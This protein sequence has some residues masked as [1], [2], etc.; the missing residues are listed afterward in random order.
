MT[1]VDHL[2]FLCHRLPFPPQKGEKIRAW[3]MLLHL[4]K[5][6]RVH[7]GCF[8]D[9]PGD[10]Q[11]LGAV[12]RVCA[13]LCAIPLDPLR[14]RLKSLVALATGEPLSTRYFHDIRLTRWVETV[15]ETHRPRHVLAYC[16]SMAPYG[17]VPGI[18][19]RVLDLV[20]VDSEKWRDYATATAWP[21][22]LV[23]RREGATL[24][25]LERRMAAAFDTTLL[26]S[27]D[28]AATFARRAP[29]VAD[30]LR[31]LGNGVDDTYFQPD[32]DRPSPYEAGRPVAVFTGTMDYRPNVDAVV[33]FVEEILP[34][35][36]SRIP[37]VEFWIVGANPAPS[38]M[39]LQRRSNVHV[40]GRVSDV[41]PYLAHAGAV[42][43]PLRIARGIQNKVLEGMAMARPVVATPAALEGLDVVV[44]EDV[45]AATT[46]E[47]F[48]A[49][50][51]AAFGPKGP[52]IGLRARRK[53]VADY[54]WGARLALLDTLFPP[55]DDAGGPIA[56]PSLV[57]GRQ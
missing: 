19:H 37:T 11:H 4:A 2:L 35:I 38:V 52:E 29:E 49:T 42:V 47:A 36:Q 46:A 22:S 31:V 54:R 33:W 23:Y 20:D 48:A 10:A 8:Y 12:H 41:R 32:V 57:R 21:M 51:I 1:A 56:T 14:T 43:A 6:H 40:T 26:V 5:R 16:S 28:E 53:V 44:G 17:L 24:L 50:V 45:L 3:Q 30:S 27:R 34:L 25:T 15:V 18:A 9:D 13:S 7:L 55:S 39:N